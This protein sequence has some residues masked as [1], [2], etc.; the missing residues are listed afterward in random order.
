MK[1]T[2]GQSEIA[3]LSRTEGMDKI[4]TSDFYSQ[5][6]TK[7]D[8]MSKIRSLDPNV[9]E[10]DYLQNC[11]SYVRPWNDDEVAYISMVVEEAHHL[12]LI[13]I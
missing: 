4:S 3:F 2:L 6:L 13:H 9:T 8:C 12:S 1:A 10:S 7:F 11:R 5:G